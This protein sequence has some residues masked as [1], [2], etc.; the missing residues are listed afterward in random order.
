[1]TAT[2]IFDFF[3]ERSSNV[4]YVGIQTLGGIRFANVTFKTPRSAK[5]AANVPYYRIDYARLNVSTA[6]YYR[7]ETNIMAL[8]EYCFIEIFRHATFV[9]SYNLSRSCHRLRLLLHMRFPEIFKNKHII[10]SQAD[11]KVIDIIRE[12]GYQ[13]ES[14]RLRCSLNSSRPLSGTRILTELEQH[15]KMLTSLEMV[16]YTFCNLR[17][18][19]WTLSILCSR[20]RTFKLK[21]GKVSDKLLP[22]FNVEDMDLIEIQIIRDNGEAEPMNRLKT[23]KL[24]EHPH[25]PL[26][27]SFLRLIKEPSPV[28]HLEVDYNTKDDVGNWNHEISNHKNLKK[29]YS[30]CRGY[31]RAT[32]V[33][34]A[35]SLIQ[36]LPLLTEFVLGYPIELTP[37]GLLRLIDA[38]QNLDQLVVICNY[39]FNKRFPMNLNE[40]RFDDMWDAVARRPN[41]KRL[42]V[43]LVGNQHQLAPFLFEYPAEA[44]I[45]ITCVRGGAIIKFLGLDRKDYIRMT[46]KQIAALYDK[47]LLQ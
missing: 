39:K 23:L 19:R 18:G 32:E 2:K 10:L 17:S 35:A 24:R 7:E 4:D 16:G 27:P 41:Q 40:S 3:E 28:E 21:N 43:I 46:D 33:A 38:G 22:H 11:D 9:D 15:C 29:L 25:V 30:F 1:M 5:L 20:L 12:Y 6:E 8:N 36:T 34:M 26:G 37:D 31:M 47:R 13:M 45:K 42:N 14:I 44:P